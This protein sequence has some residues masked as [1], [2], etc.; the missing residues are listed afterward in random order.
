MVPGQDL[1]IADFQSGAR[2]IQAARSTMLAY[3]VA[4]GLTRLARVERSTRRLEERN[5]H[6]SRVP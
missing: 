2:V 6:K 3:S 4:S 1:L 5:R